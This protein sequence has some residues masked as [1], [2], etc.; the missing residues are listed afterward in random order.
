VYTVYASTSDTSTTSPRLGLD[1]I[2]NQSD[3]LLPPPRYRDEPD[4]VNDLKLAWA[5]SDS[6]A[7]QAGVIGGI[8]SKDANRSNR[9]GVL[10]GTSTKNETKSVGS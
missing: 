9:S 5:K 1:E 3:R 8:V 4:D 10:H 6:D 2:A 7:K